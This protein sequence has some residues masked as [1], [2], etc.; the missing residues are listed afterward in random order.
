V[1]LVRPADLVCQERWEP[2]V[3]QD[4]LD[5]RES[6]AS[7]ATPAQMDYRESAERKEIWVCLEVLARKDLEA[8]REYE[9]ILDHQDFEDFLGF[10]AKR[11]RWEIAVSPAFRASP[12]QEAI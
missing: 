6:Q 8:F 2:P 3:Y 7:R 1:T 12:E 10:P 9:A 4:D 11:G 5:R